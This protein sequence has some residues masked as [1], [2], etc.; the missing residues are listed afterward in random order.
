MDYEVIIAYD[1]DKL[2]DLVRAALEGGWKL[3]GGIAVT[4]GVTGDYDGTEHWTMY[5]QAI[6]KENSDV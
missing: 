5:A 4:S 2:I 3:Q 1:A 6:V